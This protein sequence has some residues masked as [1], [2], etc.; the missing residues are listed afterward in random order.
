MPKVQC[1]IYLFYSPTE[2]D[3]EV[4]ISYYG[5]LQIGEDF[6]LTCTVFGVENLSRNIAYQ[7]AKSSGTSDAQIINSSNTLSFLPLV[8]S[9]GGLYTCQVEISSTYLNRIITFND[10]RNVSVQSK[11]Q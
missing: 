5:I 11:S 4:N 6:N 3:I 10:S 1:G 9:D 2:L 7:W 8:Y